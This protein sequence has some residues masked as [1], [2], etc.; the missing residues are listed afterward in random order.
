MAVTKTLTAAV[1]YSESGKVVRWELAMKYEQG[2]EGKDDYYASEK[3]TVIEATE[4][5]PSTGGTVTVNNFTA[6]A[7]KDWTKKELED[8]CPTAQWDDV[9]A[10]QYDSVITNPSTNPVANNEFSIPS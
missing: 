1:P 4:T 3:R 10:S 5:R 8:L 7:E 6:K 2:T 9:F